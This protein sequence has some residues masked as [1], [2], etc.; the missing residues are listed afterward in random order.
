MTGERNQGRVEERPQKGWN[1]RKEWPIGG[2]RQQESE[3]EGA[4]QTFRFSLASTLNISD[5]QEGKGLLPC[6][7]SPSTLSLNKH[8][9]Q[10]S[11]PEGSHPSCVR[12]SG[13]A[14][15]TLF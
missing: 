5:L 1:S 15:I 10:T 6:E 2:R 11:Q 14:G 8:G 3:V 7:N 9:N 13:L 12:V 4:A